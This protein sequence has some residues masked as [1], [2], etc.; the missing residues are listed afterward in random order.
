MN[1]Y[2]PVPRLIPITLGVFCLISVNSIGDAK[3][4]GPTQSVKEKETGKAKGF[5]ARRPSMHC[6]TPINPEA[7]TKPTPNTPWLIHPGGVGHIPPDGPFPQSILELEGKTYDRIYFG[8]LKG[9][10]EDQNMADK[11]IDQDGYRTI[12]LSKVDL[13]IRV[14]DNKR[15]MCLYPGPSLRTAQGTGIGSTLGQLLKAHG[16]YTLHRIPEPHRCAVSVSGLR[17]LSFQFK[18]CEAACAGEPVL[19]IYF[20]GQDAWGKNDLAPTAT[21]PKDCRAMPQ[22]KSRGACTGRAGQ[23]AATTDADCR[24]STRCASHGLCT[25]KGGT[26]ISTADADCRA[27]TRCSRNGLCTAKE[28][29]CIAT[30]QKDCKASTELCAKRGECTATRNACRAISNADCKESLWCKERGRCTAH[31]GHCLTFSNKSCTASAWCKQQGKCS[32]SDGFCQAGSNADCLASE[33]CKTAQRCRL[34]QDHAEF[35]ACVR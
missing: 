10:S 4:T 27:S 24:V 25:A 28:D 14:T 22:C 32:A 2:S 30:S 9:K 21:A 3:E 18:S 7:S 8:P 6:P 16:D 11:H 34:G 35:P 26:W 31:L 12:K 17:G 1:T 29:R 20:P 19:R 23:C 5:A 15:V 13:T 33:G